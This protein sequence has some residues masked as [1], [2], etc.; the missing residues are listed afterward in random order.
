M[1][2]T[3][4]SDL[5]EFDA[6]PD[7]GNTSRL[8]SRFTED[9]LLFLP[10]LLDPAVVLD[11]R[12]QVVERLT[13]VGWLRPGPQRD[14]ARPGA[15][16]HHDTGRVN[17]REVVDLGWAE[18][19]RAV[20]SIEALHALAHSPSV[21]SVVE[22]LVGPRVVVHPRKIARIGF[23]GFPFP[24]PPHQDWLFNSP[25]V[26]V[27]TAWMPLGPTPTELGGL[28]VLPGSA[29]AGPRRVVPSDG[30]GGEAA[31]TDDSDAGWAATDYQAGDV[32]FFHGFTVHATG[33]NLG[34]QVRLSM[35]CRY[36]SADEPIHPNALL[37]HHHAKGVLPGWSTLTKGWASTRAV[38]V[39]EAVW[40]APVRP[41]S[42][43]PSTLARWPEDV[44]LK[45]GDVDCPYERPISS[46]GN[47][48][49]SAGRRHTN[50]RT[51]TDRAPTAAPA[52]GQVRV[53]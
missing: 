38:E 49:K 17:G 28:R 32:I 48:G 52:T 10:R 6:S 1:P 53:R 13:A 5:R 25:A 19:Y 37:P 46:N 31:L 41:E 16:A 24:T 3:A 27:V 12:C 50:G 15:F 21:R 26:D 30:L 34:D 42:C 33:P 29:I 8:R 2:N 40:I 44:K 23:P 7:L 18:G 4:V 45:R 22:A 51:W 43:A 47:G 39:E 36:Q 9:G 11:V 14:L 35:D 20:Q